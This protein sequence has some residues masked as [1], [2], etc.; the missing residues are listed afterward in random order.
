MT[1]LKH[2]NWEDTDCMQSE[3]HTRANITHT[4]ITAMDYLCLSACLV[5]VAFFVGAI[6]LAR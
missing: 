4:G 1:L 3:P 5:S 6:R 2:I